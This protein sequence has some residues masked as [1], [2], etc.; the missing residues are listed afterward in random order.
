MN[1]NT[2]QVCENLSASG[3]SNGDAALDANDI[4]AYV[5]HTGSGQSLGTVIAQNT[6]GTFNFQAGMT[7][8]QTY[9]ISYVVGNNVA[10]APDPMDPCFSVAQGQPVVFEQNPTA[11]AGADADTCSLVLTLNGNT[12]VGTGTWMLIGNPPGGNLTLSNPLSPNST[13]T[14]D[15]PGVYTLTWTLDNA[16]CTASDQVALDFHPNS[17]GT[18][19]AQQLSACEGLSVTAQHLGGQSNNP[20]DIGAYVLHTGNGTALGTV[21]DQN[22]TGTFSFLNGMTYGQ[23]YYVSFV[24]AANL[25]GAPDLNDPCLTV[26]AGQ[27]VV[28][29]QNPVPNAGADDQICGN[30][31]TL[32]ANAATGTG[33]WTLLNS[34]AGGSLSFDDTQNPATGVNATAFGAYTLLW[35]VTQNGCTGTDQVTV[36]F[37][38]TPALA[39]LIRTCDAANENF[40]VTLDLNGGLP[41]Y[42][43]NGNPVLGNSF[44]SAPIPNGQTYSFTV[45]DA[46]GCI[47]PDVTGAYSCDCATDAGTMALQQLSACET[48]TVT[49]QANADATLD[50][51]DVTAFVLHTGSGAALGTVLAANSTGTFGFQPGMTYGTVY[52]I[53]RV[54]ATGL[55]GAPDPNDPCFSVAPGQPVVFL[56]NPTPDAG[57]AAAI[58]G[59]TIDLQAINDGFQGSWSQISGPG[60][61]TFSAIN[62][63]TS[64]ATV[65]ATGV[66]VYR[67]TETNSICTGTDDVTITFQELPVV[68][69]IDEIC[70]GT[71][72]AYTVSFSVSGGTPAY[73]LTGINGGFSGNTFTSNPLPNGSS[74]SFTVSDINGC[75]AAPAAGAHNC[76]CTTDAGTMQVTALAFCADQQAV[77]TWN[78]DGQ[79]DADDIIRFI[80][81]DQANNSLGTVFGTSQ[82]P[83][84]PFMP[85]LQ[86]G[87][88]YYISAIAGNQQIGGINLNDPCLSIAPGTPVQWKPIPTATLTG[89]ATICNGNSA[90]LTFSGTGQFPLTLIYSDS[91]A[92]QST[93]TLN[94]NQPFNVTVQP[95][96]TTTYSLL[97][98]QD[99]TLPTCSAAPG[100]TIQITV[101]QPVN[102]GAAA[103]PFELCAGQ[104][105]VVQLSSLLIGADAGGQWS[106]TSA[107]PSKPGTSTRQPE[108][109]KHKA[110][111]RAPTL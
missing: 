89:D 55:A 34:P 111:F 73:T 80:L 19:A 91:Q 52:Y 7:Y 104:N 59:Q 76:N 57:P 9:Y 96:S 56:K 51:N 77:A 22:N 106:E 65:D 49:A 81:H 20:G 109:S 26:S 41:P 39:N 10:G 29:Y 95:G 82:Q 84:F 92:G 98:V 61:T 54:A 14:A 94:N 99:G 58:C 38:E 68:G 78:N 79:T 93:V 35:T 31:L 1:L 30:T 15:L 13:A 23:T 24:V 87:V 2:I 5:L 40:T 27:P 46:N 101:N 105:S 44:T 107:I 74:Y 3:A 86:F 50:G 6:T 18:M 47:M 36:Q 16:G 8:G 67:W 60:A 75:A 42:A 43:V 110:K 97:S 100:N 90:T 70:N 69:V 4:G 48:A 103:A 28:F 37:D 62:S 32:N 72:T 45:S 11:N 53:S 12:G 21:L 71:N 63:Q 108:Y 25:N 66:Y 102:A 85:G 88:T 64:G 33:S 83:S 17:A